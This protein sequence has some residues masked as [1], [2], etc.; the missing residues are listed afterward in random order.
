ML[1]NSKWFAPACDRIYKSII[2]DAQT[3]IVHRR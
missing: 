3:H 1:R 2:R